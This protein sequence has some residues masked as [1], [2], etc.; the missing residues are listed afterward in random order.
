MSKQHEIQ[1]VLPL[2]KHCHSDVHSYIPLITL[3]RDESDWLIAEPSFNLS[4]VAP[5][6]SALSLKF[7]SKKE[8]DEI[9][10]FC[11]TKATQKSNTSSRL[12]NQVTSEAQFW[13]IK[14]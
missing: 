13:V 3:P 9:R 14:L 7:E 4:P 10:I 11:H 5:V 2:T 12:Q 1:V 6:E 8:K